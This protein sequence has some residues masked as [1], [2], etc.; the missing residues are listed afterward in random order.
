MLQ[1]QVSAQVGIDSLRRFSEEESGLVNPVRKS[2]ISIESGSQTI[3]FS[4]LRP[5]GLSLFSNG[6]KLY[7][8]STLSIT[9]N[10]PGARVYLDTLFIGITPLHN[11]SLKPGN[12]VLK[13]L[14]PRIASWEMNNIIKDITISPGEKVVLDLQFPDSYMKLPL[15]ASDKAILLGKADFTS[16]NAHLYIVAGTGLLSGIAA[17]Y[18][19]QQA[20][21]V[22]DDYQRTSNPSLLDRTR[23]YDKWSGVALVIFELSFAALTY[24]LLSD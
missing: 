15:K 17:A 13:I 5:Y 1:N 7:E 4:S 23:L 10:L 2:G 20:D 6:V 3:R 12:Y 11:I 9:T 24:F 21:R 19:K 16:S 22:F 18:F 8:Q 14:N